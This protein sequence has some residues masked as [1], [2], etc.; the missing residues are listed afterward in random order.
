MALTC[1]FLFLLLS[2]FWVPTIRKHHFSSWC[3][4]FIILLY[5]EEYNDTRAHNTYNAIHFRALYIYICRRPSTPPLSCCWLVS[6]L[7]QK[8]HTA[9]VKRRR[10]KKSS[11]DDQKHTSLRFRSKFT[12][13]DLF[14]RV[15]LSFALFR[16]EE[17]KK[18][19]KEERRGTTTTQKQPSERR[20]QRR[21][22]EK[23][24]ARRR[25]HRHLFKGNWAPKT[26]PSFA[27]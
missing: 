5:K 25:H 2:F 9:G 21:R 17:E 4:H 12:C 11:T 15:S 18:K 7:F 6:L 26:V 8:K 1:L 10:R 3:R 13:I 20:R 14:A 24:S 27:I 23:K 16:E 19:H 22:E